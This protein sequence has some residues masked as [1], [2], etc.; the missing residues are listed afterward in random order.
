MKAAYNAVID[1]QKLP[2]VR[3]TGIEFEA[4]LKEDLRAEENAKAQSSAMDIDEDT[5]VAEAASA[6]PD[7]SARVSTPAC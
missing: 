4:A 3:E 5:A 6:G 2:T 1:D 7:V